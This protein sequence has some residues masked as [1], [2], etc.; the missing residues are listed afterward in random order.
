MRILV[1]TIRVGEWY[2]K[3][4]K[5]AFQ[6]LQQYCNKHNYDLLESDISL[7]TTRPI[8]WSKIPFI[9]NH[10]NKYDF[11]VW[12]DADIFIMNQEI[13]LEDL[14][15][16]HLTSN[17]D[18]A[19]GSDNVMLNSGFMMIRNTKYSELFLWEIYYNTQAQNGNNWEQDSIKDL[20]DRN[21]LF[22]RDHVKIISPPVEVNSYWYNYERGHF[23]IHAAGARNEALE[24]WMRDWCPIQREN[25]S[26]DYFKWKTRW[27]SGEG[28]NTYKDH[29][30][31]LKA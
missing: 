20:Y 8:P 5:Y 12:I 23:I 6:V 25:D 24:Q 19:M 2:R 10:L 3:T 16:K 26:D 21:I 27:L 11:I 15:S 17:I 7:D 13:K 1:L 30:R 31:R 9:L 18:I 22:S 14:I 28:E 4:T 29:V